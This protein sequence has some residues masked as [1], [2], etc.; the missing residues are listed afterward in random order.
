MA[1][2]IRDHSGRDKDS[3]VYKHHIMTSIV[4][5]TI[6]DMQL[7]AKGFKFEKQRELSE[8]FLIKEQKPTLYIQNFF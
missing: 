1:D 6:A 3:I 5:V 2:R 8:A 4:P 7:I